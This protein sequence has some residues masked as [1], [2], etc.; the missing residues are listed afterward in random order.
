MVW[1][2]KHRGPQE[3]APVGSHRFHRF[4]ENGHEDHENRFTQ[5]KAPNDPNIF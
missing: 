5:S 4:L 1:L 2:V 3:H